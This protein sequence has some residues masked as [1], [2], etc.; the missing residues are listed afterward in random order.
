MFTPRHLAELQRYEQD[1]SYLD[2]AGYRQV[3][4]Q[5]SQRERRLLQRMKLLVDP[6]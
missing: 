6:A 5:T 4:L 1:P 3:L 2:A